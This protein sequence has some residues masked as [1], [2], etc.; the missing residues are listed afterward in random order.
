MSLVTVARTLI[1][2][3]GAAWSLL[4]AVHCAVLPLLL[5][6][7]PG[8]AL[9]VWWDEGVERVTV[10]GVTVVALGSLGLGYRRHRAFGAL[11]MAIPGLALM[12]MALL[13]TPVHA[14]VLSHALAMASGGVM[15]GLAHLYNLRL[16]RLNG[17][18]VHTP[19][20]THPPHA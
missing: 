9:G 17:G 8:L 16:N 12:W 18:H 13:V 11:L 20:C 14:S 3:L 10:T 2:R 5:V 6:V 1:D 19:G 4:C 7:M 15:V